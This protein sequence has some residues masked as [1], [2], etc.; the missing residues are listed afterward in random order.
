[1]S[2]SIALINTSAFRASPRCVSG[3]NKFQKDTGD[4]CLVRDKLFQLIKSPGMVLSPLAFSNNRSGTDTRQVF[5]GY[6]PSSVF[7]LFNNFLGDDMINVSSKTGF[8]SFTLF[9]KMFSRFSFL[10]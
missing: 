3:I 9:Q 2:F 10:L 6:S 4:F 7:C 8:F 5:K 1:M